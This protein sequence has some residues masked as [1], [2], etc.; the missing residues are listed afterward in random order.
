MPARP[1]GERCWRGRADPQ[2]VAINRWDMTIGELREEMAALHENRLDPQMTIAEQA[3]VFAK[4]RALLSAGM[5]ATL[6]FEEPWPQAKVMTSEDFVIELR[7]RPAARR[8]FGRNLRQVRLYIAE[9]LAPP[10]KLLALHLASKPN[11]EDTEHEQTASIQVAAIR[12]HL[13]A[14]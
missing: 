4:L 5:S 13:W 1:T 11:G 6:N 10:D 9:P 2:N 12:A 14:T 7:P 8:A 3:D